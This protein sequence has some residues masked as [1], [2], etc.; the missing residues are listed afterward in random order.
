MAKLIPERAPLGDPFIGAVLQLEGGQQALAQTADRAGADVIVS[1]AFI[2]RYGVPYLGKPHLSIVPGMLVLDYG[3]IFTGEAAWD[4]LYN[5]SNLYPRA[6]VFGYRS[7]GRD[8]MIII[9][10]LDLALPVEVFV[11]PDEKATTPSAHPKALIATSEAGL[12]PR[13]L[14][15]LPRFETVTHWKASLP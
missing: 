11:Y 12:P 15:Y 5:R 9:R 3:D 6:E 10:S 4:F 8:D 2:V 7:D 13:L 14:K 1:D